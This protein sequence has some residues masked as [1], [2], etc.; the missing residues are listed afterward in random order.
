MRMGEHLPNRR[1]QARPVVWE[2]GVGR[3]TDS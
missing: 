2:G 1:I 3:L